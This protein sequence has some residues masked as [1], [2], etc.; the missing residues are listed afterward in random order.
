MKRFVV[1]APLLVLL[2][3]ANAFAEFRQIDLRIYGMD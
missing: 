1:L 2:N 3:A